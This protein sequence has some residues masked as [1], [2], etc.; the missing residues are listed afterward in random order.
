MEV[1]AEQTSTATESATTDSSNNA[2]AAETA[3]P[4]TPASG[5]NAP[6]SGDQAVAA[7]SVYTPNFKF[8]VMDK[9]LEIPEKYRQLV[10]D[11]TTEKEVKEIF[12]KAHGL[13][14]V[15]KSRDTVR[16]ELKSFKSQAEP[17]VN[18][19]KQASPLY[20]QAIQAFEE[21][22][23]VAG[24]HKMTEAFKLL[25]ISKKSLQQYIYADFKMEELPPEQKA[26]YN[27]ER[28]LERQLQEREQRLAA[29]EATYKQTAVQQRQF[30]LNQALS[31]PDIASIAQS[32][33]QRNGPG[34]FQNEIIHRGAF[35]A[36]QFG[37]DV[38]ANE[39]IK[40]II[41][42]YNLQAPQ[43]TT[44]SQVVQHQTV[45]VIP[46]VKGGTQSPAGRSFKSLEDIKKYRAEKFG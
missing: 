40:E 2:P 29:T 35:Y 45:P 16:E 34:S 12:E 23:Q 22:N 33:D 8:K 31:T 37:K 43:A 4:S 27:R 41:A 1:Q 20:Q 19:V 3:A 10:K 7:A 18:I 24:V 42:K 39:I 15:K 30:E 38:S 21:G 6:E 44:Q 14:E 46:A 25:G 13:D 28:E 32:F 36:Q 17:I 5:S 11:A 26:S 9:E